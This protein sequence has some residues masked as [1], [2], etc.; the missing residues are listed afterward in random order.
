[1]NDD[2]I[3]DLYWE[4]SESAITETEKTYET[5]PYTL[6]LYTR[7]TDVHC[8]NLMRLPCKAYSNVRL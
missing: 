7:L 1:M 4:R 8:Y 5:H 2:K 3:L 6:A